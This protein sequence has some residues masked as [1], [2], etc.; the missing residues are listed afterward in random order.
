LWPNF[1]DKP[2]CGADA[3]ETQ[4]ASAAMVERIESNG[5]RIIIVETADRFAS[6]LMVQVG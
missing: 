4:P 5:V 3:I 2:V 6:D 1:Y